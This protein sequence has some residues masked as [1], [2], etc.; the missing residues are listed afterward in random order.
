MILRPNIFR[1]L[2]VITP[3]LLLAEVQKKQVTSVIGLQAVLSGKVDSLEIYLQPGDY[4]LSPTSITDSTCGN[5]EEPNQFVPATAG[6]EISGSYVRITGPEDRSAVIHTNAGYGIYFNHC[7]RGIIENLSVTGGIRD[8][9]GN[10]TDAAIVVKNSAVTIRNNHIYGNIGD[11]AIVVKNIVGVMGICG[12]ENSDLTITDNEII[13]NSWDGIALYRDA[14]ATII[15]NL[16]DGVDKASSKV[17]GGGRGVAVGITWNAR[18]TIDGN[19]VKRYWKGIGIFVDANVTAR[20]NI[21]EDILT[22]GIAY[23][24]AERGKPVGI[25]ENNI[26][27]S[28]GACGVSIT[29]SQPGPNP[30]HLIGNVIVR[31]A[32]NPKYDAPDYY[33][34]QCAL[35][36]SSKPDNFRIDDNQFFNNRRATETLPDYDLSESEFKK[37]AEDLRNRLLN[38]A[39]FQQS[40][41]VK[42][43][44][45]Q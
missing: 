23:W 14:T 45:E 20:N 29:R 18:A 16:I 25:I 24:D 22:W 43:L 7:K 15:G 19:L 8:P 30:G 17:A 5:C 4:Y 44:A 37:Y 34:N 10:A 39:L 35:S 32:Q 21:I 38:S 36:I 41:F 3:L 42:F 11:S 40:D 33:C 28:T 31:T 26:I 13:G 1:I 6:L 12:R 27:Y 9:D 2:F